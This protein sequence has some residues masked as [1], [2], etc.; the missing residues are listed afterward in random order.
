MDRQVFANLD[1]VGSEAAFVGELDAGAGHDS[2][3][4]DARI[5]DLTLGDLD[6]VVG[7]E[8]EKADV[9]DAEIFDV[10]F[11]HGLLIVSVEA[12]ND[13]IEGQPGRDF[14]EFLLVGLVRGA[15]RTLGVGSLSIGVLL[16][17]DEDLMRNDLDSNDN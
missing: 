12:E 16:L 13:T 17:G 7:Q 8:I 4:R 15:V 5:R 11:W 9:T 14:V 10:G 2:G 1:V 6:S 3:S